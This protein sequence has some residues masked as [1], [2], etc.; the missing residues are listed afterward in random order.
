MITPAHRARTKSEQVRTDQRQELLDKSRLHI[1]NLLSS[2]DDSINKQAGI[3]ATATTIEIGNVTLGVT[4][5]WERRQIMDHICDQLRN[6]GYDVRI[7]K[8]NAR[9]TVDWDTV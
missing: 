5:P 3:G 8:N 7:H 4:N 6:A 9:L 2:I 1:D